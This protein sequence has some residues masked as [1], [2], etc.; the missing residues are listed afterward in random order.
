MTNFWQKRVYAEL[1]TDHDALAKRGY[2]YLMSE[3]FTIPA[4]SSVAF[5]LDTNGK[6]LQF[7][8]YDIASDTYSVQARLLEAASASFSPAAS[9]QAHNLNRN[10]PDAAT[11]SLHSASAWSGG[12]AIASELVGS[13]SKAGGD[14]STAK[15]HV[16]KPETRYVM[17]FYNTG[18]QPT[19]CHMNLGWSE[20]EPDPTPLW[21]TTDQ[22]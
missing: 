17:A 19:N 14:I 5:V 6:S 15:V 16:L 10:Y 3:F 12:T 13:G 21:V 8:F 7:E 4:T 20:G 18:N 1:S 2:V 9:V 11:A 22:Q